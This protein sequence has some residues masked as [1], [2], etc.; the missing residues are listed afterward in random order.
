[1]GDGFAFHNKKEDEE[2][3]LKKK[4]LAEQAW[5]MVIKEVKSDTWD[6]VILD[7]VNYAIHFGMIDVSHVLELIQTR[8]PRLNMILTGR[9]ARDELIE[10]ADT[11]T[12]MTLCKHAF[13]K[14]IRARKGIEF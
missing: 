8:P 5:D 7:E 6:L 12:E 2:S 4:G 1:M 10:I 11:V 3:F 13:Q 14:G 9:Y